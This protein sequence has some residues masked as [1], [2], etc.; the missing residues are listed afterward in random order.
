MVLRK[1]IKV[2]ISI[3]ELI[4]KITILQIKSEKIMQ[5]N[6]LENIHKE[7]NSLIKTRDALDL[8]FSELKEL[9]SKLKLVN[10][11][12]W[13]IEDQIRDHEKN[14]SFGT[15]FVELARKVYKSND[16]RSL[17]KRKINECAGSNIFEEKSYSDY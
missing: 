14:K 2:E 1:K 13:D 11:K 15:S 16:E 5:R 3:G 8:N 17:I 4:D 10:I 12:L 9:E 6:K 7:L